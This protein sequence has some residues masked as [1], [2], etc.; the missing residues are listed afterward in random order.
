MPKTAGKQNDSQTG[1]TS[2]VK[3]KVT[4]LGCDKEFMLL[5][6][7]LERTESCQDCY[8]MSAMRKEAETLTKERKAQRSRERY[9]H[10]PNESQ[11]KKTASKEYY[12]KHTPEKKAAS[13]EYYK[14]HTPEKKAASKEY[15]KKHTTDK[16]A[17]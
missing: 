7:H 15:Y 14:K 5:L 6:S 2:S 8:D 1:Q 11:R 3:E 17:A 10:D 13:K 16:M 12:K 9:Q 4:C